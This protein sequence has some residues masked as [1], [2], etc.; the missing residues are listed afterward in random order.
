MGRSAFCWMASGDRI[1]SVSYTH[2]DVYKR[3]VFDRCMTP[4]LGRVD[5]QKEHRLIPGRQDV[6]K[7]Q[8]LYPNRKYKNRRRCEPSPVDLAG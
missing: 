6:Y 2:L 8:P 4:E 1:P 5:Y 7:R 3:Q